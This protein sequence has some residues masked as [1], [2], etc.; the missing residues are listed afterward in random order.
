[1]ST[2]PFTLSPDELENLGPARAVEFMGRLLRD[3]AERVGIGQHLVTVPSCINVADGG[4]DALI[5]EAD[6]SDDSVIPRGNTGFQIKASD[7]QPTACKRELHKGGDLCNPLK[8]AVQNL[9]DADGNY[10]LVL[11]KSLTPVKIQNR[12]QAIKGHLASKGYSN[13]E[14]R[15]YTVDHLAP[16]AERFLGVMAW[17]KPEYSNVDSYST[18]ARN[19]DISVPCQFI[20]DDQRSEWIQEVQKV[21]REPGAECPIF[22]VTGL[23]GIG[24]TR[25]VFEALAP[26]DLQNRVIYTRADDFLRSELNRIKNNSSLSAVVVVDECDLRQHDELVRAFSRQGSRLAVITMS[27]DVGEIPPPTRLFQLNPLENTAI[28]EILRKESHNFPQEVVRGLAKFADGFPRIAI[29]LAQSYALNPGEPEEYITIRD[30][31]LM[32]RLIG[33]SIRIDPQKFNTT[34]KVLRGIALF[35]KIGYKSDNLDREAHWLSDFIGVQWNEFQEVV[36]KQQ[37]RGLIQGHYYLYV[38]PFMLKVHLLRKWWAI[39]GFTRERFEKF[40]SEIPDT[41]RADLLDRFISTIPYLPSVAHGQEFVEDILNRD[42]IFSDGMLLRTQQGGKLFLALA[43]ACPGAAMRRLR[44]TVGRWSK[45]DLLTFREGRRYVVWALEKIAIWQEHF[46]DAAQILLRLAEAE[47]DTT[48]SNNASGTFVGLFSLSYGPLASTAASPDDRFPVLSDALLSTSADVCKLALQACDVALNMRAFPILIDDAHQGLRWEPKR[49]T[50]STDRDVFEAYQKVW[51]LLRKNL[52]VLDKDNKKE[53]VAILLR[54]SQDLARF[55]DLADM[56]VETVTELATHDDIDNLLVLET[57]IMII[58]Y[59]RDW[60]PEDTRRKWERLRDDLVGFDYHSRMVRYVRT[61]LH[62]DRRDEDGNLVDQKLEK[63]RELAKESLENPAFLQK[64]MDWL[65]T[66]KADDGFRFGYEL[67]KIDVN[68]VFLTPLIDAQRKTEELFS[69]FFLGGYFR[70]FVER[71]P[72]KWEDKIEALANDPDTQGWI[73][74]LTWRSR[75]PSEKS[76]LRILSLAER[77][78][79]LPEDFGIFA[80][81]GVIRNLSPATFHKWIRFLLGHDGMASVSN[82]LKLFYM[83]YRMDKD[84]PEM[85]NQ[86]AFAIIRHRIWFQQSEDRRQDTNLNYYWFE[87]AKVI[88]QDCPQK[89]LEL[90]DQILSTETILDRFEY[91][92]ALQRVLDEIVKR[93]PEDVW[94]LVTPYLEPPQRPMMMREWLGGSV[95]RVGALSYIPAESIW[96]W[97]DQDVENRAGYLAR[98]IP[99]TLFHGNDRVCLARELLV[100]YGNRDDVRRS[101]HMNYSTGVWRQSPMSQSYQETKE[102]LRAFQKDEIDPNV[103]RWIDEHI[104]RLKRDIKRAEIEEERYG[105]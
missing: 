28:E 26:D 53:A 98:C 69:L 79:V 104:E 13:A 5:E 102:N 22:R 9:L 19:G 49:W 37:Q 73:C 46:R 10:V 39:N 74:E 8:P 7:L 91:N 71:D 48:Y 88:I 40:V 66:T 42:G 43:E 99:K 55:D 31:D 1:M 52:T 93:F 86:L 89:A 14:V 34:K 84:T 16:M 35:E 75:I 58:H 44:D 94:I 83:Y 78:V 95:N 23:P 105:F 87:I 11:F 77:G 82:A 27:Y 36:H 80:Y 24:K 100:R 59:E 62:E 92:S 67:S 33:G 25:L 4:I 96:Q 17:F 63:I 101:F 6:P 81:G 2:L 51:D 54:R 64:E 76:G 65:T 50:P 70:G 61:D 85:P 20:S 57:A 56:V 38:T 72:A 68:S 45:D 3:E 47:I 97:I 12:R 21:L 103:I 30:D 18:W 29:L 90:A 15:L 32:N 60:L 41:F